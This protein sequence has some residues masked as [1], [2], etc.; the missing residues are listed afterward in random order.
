MLINKSINDL[1]KMLEQSD[2]NQIEQKITD[3][4]EV[5]ADF[6]ERR[7]DNSIHKALSGKSIDSLEL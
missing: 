4:N 3:L 6:A 1:I 5:T 2:R 7:M